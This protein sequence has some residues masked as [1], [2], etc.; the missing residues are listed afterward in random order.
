[1]ASVNDDGFSYPIV[2]LPKDQGQEHHCM[3][4]AEN[5]ALGLPRAGL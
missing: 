2:I 3:E 4:R 1:M 5:K